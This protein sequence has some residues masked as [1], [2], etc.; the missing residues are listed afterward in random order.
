MP[1]LAREPD[2]CPET[3][4]DDSD[5]QSEHRQ[6]KAF[7]TKPSQEKAFAR[8]L[9]TAEIPFYLPLVK[10]TSVYSNRHVITSWKPLFPGYVFVCGSKDECMESLSTR[11]VVRILPV[12]DPD[13]LLQDLR[14]IRK[15][16]ASGA[17]V[18]P[19]RR[20]VRGDRVRVRY[21]PL[22]GFE[23]VVLVRHRRTRLLVSVDFLQQGASIEI[24]D[25][26]LEP[27]D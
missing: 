24:D 13:R 22:A 8:E 2:L 11:R 6:W 18:T 9:L 3:L 19:E 15:L 27:I 20:L 7:Y 17:P 23:G 4:L 26:M 16:I 25:F 10:K 21:G 14:R 1:V 5:Y 12:H